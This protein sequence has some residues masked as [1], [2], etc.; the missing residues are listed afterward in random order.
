VL[1]LALAA[2]A[3]AAPW[4]TASQT[5]GFVGVDS[6][7][8]VSSSGR[9]QRVTMPSAKP[10]RFRLSSKR[11]H[12]LKKHVRAADFPHLRRTYGSQNCADGFVFHL[13]HGKYEVTVIQCGD[14]IPR[15][16]ADLIDDVASL[17]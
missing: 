15:R 1:A 4:L 14:R 6:S 5:G 8:T 17:M 13:T 3:S 2:P 12:A 16:L 10:M 11:L 7:L 9:A